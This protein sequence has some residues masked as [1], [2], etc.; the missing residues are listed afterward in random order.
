MPQQAPCRSVYDYKSNNSRSSRILRRC[1][2]HEPPHHS[3]CVAPSSHASSQFHLSNRLGN[4]NNWHKHWLGNAFEHSRLRGR[5]LPWGRAVEAATS[6]QSLPRS[7]PA[8][9]WRHLVPHPQL[10][11]GFWMPLM[12]LH[13]NV[14]MTHISRLLVSQETILFFFFFSL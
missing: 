10:R 2:C 4:S 11:H 7:E 12:L 14:D 6:C 13:R 3:D 9:Q 5:E 8:R 1:S